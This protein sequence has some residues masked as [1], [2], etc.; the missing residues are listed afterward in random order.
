[1]RRRRGRGCRGPDAPA[2]GRSAAAKAEA[3]TEPVLKRTPQPH[4]RRVILKGV[5][6]RVLTGYSQGIKGVLKGDS[7]GIKGVL[8]GYSR[9]THNG[10]QR[11]THRVLEEEP[12]SFARAPVRR[13]TAAALKPPRATAATYP[14]ADVAPANSIITIRPV[15]REPPST[16]QY[17]EYREYRAVPR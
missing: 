1:M 8:K 7:R 6:I 11:G 3:S 12:R 10:T 14:S 17:R 15:S 2:D 13:M 5:L 16:A 9:G 4:A